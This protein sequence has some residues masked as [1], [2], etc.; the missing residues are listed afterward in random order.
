LIG[1]SGQGAE[2]VLAAAAELSRQAAS[3]SRDARAFT[4]KIRAA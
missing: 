1:K 4:G 2:Q 3:L